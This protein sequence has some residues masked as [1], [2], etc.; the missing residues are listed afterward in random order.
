MQRLMVGRTALHNDAATLAEAGCDD[1]VTVRLSAM[2]KT[3]GALLVHQSSVR[4]HVASGG[5]S[6]IKPPPEPVLVGG[7]GPTIRFP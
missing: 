5:I 3:R 1:Q 6:P 4:E 2:S 7:V